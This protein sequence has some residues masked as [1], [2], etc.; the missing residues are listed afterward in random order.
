LL[1]QRPVP[2]DR[3]MLRFAR[4]LTPGG[5][6]VIQVRGA[7][8]LSGAT[9]DGQVMLV[10]PERPKTPPDSTRPAPARP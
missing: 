4:P 2:A 9:A 6:Y 1:R 5:K 10:V 7:R 3:V 8:N